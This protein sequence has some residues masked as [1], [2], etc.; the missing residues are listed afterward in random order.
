LGKSWHLASCVI[1]FNCSIINAFSH[2][3]RRLE[4]LSWLFVEFRWTGTILPEFIWARAICLCFTVS[5]WELFLDFKWEILLWISFVG[6]W[7][8][9]DIYTICLQ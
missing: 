5:S 3:R 1:D 7:L 8:I 6:C 9:R 2:F 4:E